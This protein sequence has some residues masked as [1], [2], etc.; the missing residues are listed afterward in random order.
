MKRTD[1]DA[2]KNKRN[3]AKS[4]YQL[5]EELLAY[6]SHVLLIDQMVKEDRMYAM[7]NKRQDIYRVNQILA[8]LM[9]NFI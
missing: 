4:A 9:K 2:E 6:H 8:Q 5:V 1:I 7:K 3:K